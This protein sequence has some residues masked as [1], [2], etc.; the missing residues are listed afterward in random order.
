MRRRVW[1]ALVLGVVL[2]LSGCSSEDESPAPAGPG[3]DIA[4][5]DLEF[6]P[7]IATY[8]LQTLDPS[9]G[10]TTFASYASTA[11]DSTVTVRADDYANDLVPETVQ[12]YLPPYWSDAKGLQSYDNGWTCATLVNGPRC[13]RPLTDGM[14]T[15]DCPRDECRLSRDQLAALGATFHEALAGGSTAGGTSKAPVPCEGVDIDAVNRALAP[16]LGDREAALSTGESENGEFYTC[17]VNLP[18]GAFRAGAAQ[19]EIVRHS[20]AADAE[21]GQDD[22]VFGGTDADAVYSSAAECLLQVKDAQGVRR[23]PAPD[24]APGGT[25]VSGPAVIQAEEGDYWWELTLTDERFPADDFDALTDLAAT[26]PT[27]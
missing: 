13:Y 21:S 18:P 19:L 24:D 11:D 16:V 7:G 25:V 3:P 1:A 15:L 17:Y 22:C 27:E 14:L 10:T 8:D 4:Y 5:A 12:G 20:Y 6:R 23:V 26:L 2:V 9:L